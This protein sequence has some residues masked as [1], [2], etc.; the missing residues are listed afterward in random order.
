MAN[1]TDNILVGGAEI[2]IGIGTP[3][4]GVDGIVDAIKTAS[5]GTP[6]DF[7]GWMNGLGRTGGSALGSTGVTF[8]DVGFTSEGVEITYTPDYQD[9]EV[10]QLLDAARIYKQKMT[11]MIKTSFAEATLENLVYVWDLEDSYL[12]SDSDYKKLYMV[13]G[14]L[15]DKPKERVVVFAGNAPVVSGSTRQRLYVATRA[16]SVSASTHGVKRN[17][18]TSFPVELR[19]LPDNNSSYSSYG[20]IVDQI[21]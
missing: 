16:L 4:V 21:S 5:T 19:L 11:V 17:S 6:K 20:A 14:E 12:T 7:R 8:Y 3:S 15:G 18:P 13:P 2:A 10:D 1:Q 9:V